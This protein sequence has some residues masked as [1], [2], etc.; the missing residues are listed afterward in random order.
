MRRVLMTLFRSQ[1]VSLSLIL[2]LITPLF[3]SVCRI[4]G[5]KGEWHLEVDGKPYELRGMGCA[6]FKGED[7]TDY[8]A[9]AKEAG[10]NTLRTWGIEQGN[11]EYLNEARKYGLKVDAGIWLPHGNWMKK[12]KVFSYL[13]NAQKLQAI[14]DQVLAYV[15]HYKDHPAIIFWN[16]GNEVLANTLET[17][18]KI[19]FC[20]FL[21]SLAK[22][23]KAIDSTHPVLYTCA[24]EANLG[25][26]KAYAPSLDLIGFNTYSGVQH[27]HETWQSFDFSIP[28]VITEFGP[29]GP[30]DCPKDE[31]GTS[32]DEADYEKAFHY[33][34]ILEEIPTF[35][36]SCLGGFVFH[37]G[38][39]S[40]E[41]LTWWNLTF[42]KM[43]RDSF[44]TVKKFYTG[45]GPEN[46]PP[47]CTSLQ[48]DRN[49]VKPGEK[50]RVTITARDPEKGPL[51]YDILVSTAYEDIVQ[52]RVNRIIKVAKTSKENQVEFEVPYQ[53]G[54]YKIH[55]LVF[56]DA[57]NV[58]VRTAA[59]QVGNGKEEN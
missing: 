58:A 2:F 47:V 17:E 13:D 28:Y 1:L 8:F 33:Q 44:Y 40:Q 30:W 37:L 29:L 41:S 25:Y 36:G 56:D 43:K 51:H 22:K 20:R 57:S 52:Y 26:L 39:T 34:V 24:G 9:L 6:V 38:D 11:E 54:I 49:K 10:A 15:T 4:V 21:D 46:N 19:A 16:L 27:L 35:K 7:G 23:V 42:G 14:E 3:S 5:K 48:L 53:P 31:F 18:E 32:I 59:F 50:I 45:Q 12:E 55:G